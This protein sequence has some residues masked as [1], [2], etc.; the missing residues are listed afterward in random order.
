MRGRGGAR[1]FSFLWWVGGLVFWGGK[2]RGNGEGE[3]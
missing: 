2:G 1:C 3:G